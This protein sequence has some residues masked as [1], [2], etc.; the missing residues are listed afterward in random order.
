[1]PILPNG[2]YGP[3]SE[4]HQRELGYAL[5]RLWSYVG[6]CSLQCRGRYLLLLAVSC[7][8]GQES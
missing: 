4:A 5:E 1:M 8:E 7:A 2:Q 3:V 6:L